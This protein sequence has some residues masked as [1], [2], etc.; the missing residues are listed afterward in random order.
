MR[1]APFFMDGNEFYVAVPNTESRTI[2]LPTDCP[3]LFAFS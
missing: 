1:L 2:S 3:P